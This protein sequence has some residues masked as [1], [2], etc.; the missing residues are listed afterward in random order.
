[1]PLK[2]SLGDDQGIKVIEAGYP[3]S[4]P[5]NGKTMDPDDD[6]QATKSAGGTSALAY[7][8]ASGRYIYVWKTLKAWAGTCRYL[9]LQ[10]ADGTEHRA[11]FMFK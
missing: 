3:A 8:P 5:L 4:G 9:S 11:A 1:V 2:F 10:L 7:D 6:L